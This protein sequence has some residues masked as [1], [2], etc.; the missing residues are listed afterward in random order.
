MSVHVSSW[1]WKL[2]VGDPGLKLVLVKL[3]DNA[4]DA[5]YS[6]WRQRR[7]AEE[8]EMSRSTVQTKLARLVAMGLL[9]IEDRHGRDGAQLANGYRLKPPPAPAS[10]S[11]G[12]ASPGEAPPASPGEAPE[13]S[14]E[15]SA[16]PE[17]GS[18]E[19][20]SRQRPRDLIF[21]ALAGA[22]GVEIDD[23]PRGR[24]GRGPWNAAVR[25]L[26]AE[27]ASP[28]EILAAAARYRKT[29]P[30][31]SLTPMAL[32]K[33]FALLRAEKKRIVPLAPCPECE[34]G[35]GSHAA[36]CSLA[37][38]ETPGQAHRRW[39]AE[40]VGSLPA[41]DVAAVIDSWDGI[42][43]VKRLELHE[44]A[45]RLREERAVDEAEAA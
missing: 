22:I 41:A 21:E 37:V 29:W 1:A 20:L 30:A 33:H 31:V 32:A 6:R 5:G 9:E 39:I 40:S 8:C 44:F 16:E 28:D 12:G 4:D 23:V 42:D 14:V 19:P 25:D 2:R 18:V 36:G 38:R 45:E 34:T 10:D 17:R 26:K 11:G 35:G 27:D 13:P 43:P 24:A 15:P 7:L 3:A